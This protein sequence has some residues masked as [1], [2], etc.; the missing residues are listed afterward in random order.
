MGI[1]IKRYFFAAVL[2][3]SVT[4]LAGCAHNKKARCAD[5]P[6]WG[7]TQTL[8]NPQMHI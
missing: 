7:A 8:Q 5:C 4:L 2:S 1:L 3:L 6:K